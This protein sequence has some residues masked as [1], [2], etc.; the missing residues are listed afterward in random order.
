MYGDSVKVGVPILWT[1]FSLHLKFQ[2]FN[3]SVKIYTTLPLTLLVSSEI[4]MQAA[5]CLDHFFHDTKG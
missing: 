2:E 1:F 4:R 5:N 3:T